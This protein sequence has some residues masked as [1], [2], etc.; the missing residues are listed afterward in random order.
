VVD[1]SMSFELVRI[2]QEGEH[3]LFT[4]SMYVIFICVVG[5]YFSMYHDKRHP[6]VQQYSCKYTW[7]CTTKE[8]TRLR[9]ITFISRL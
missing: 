4:T 3:G 2:N 5:T 8:N 7:H 6:H 9:S 1:E